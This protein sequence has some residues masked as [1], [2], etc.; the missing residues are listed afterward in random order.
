[1]A[2]RNE[3]QNLSRTAS[4][5]GVPVKWLREKALAGKIPCLRISDS[6]LLFNIEAVEKALLDLA[7]GDKK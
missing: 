7:A 5:V 3:L 1:M 2:I 4:E 6:R